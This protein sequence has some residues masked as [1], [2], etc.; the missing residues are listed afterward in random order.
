MFVAAGPVWHGTVAEQLELQASVARNCICTL[1]P[2]FTCAAHI[3]MDGDQRAIDGLLFARKIVECLRREEGL[4][5][6]IPNN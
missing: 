4:L 3:M 5:P 2:V 6:R 1:D